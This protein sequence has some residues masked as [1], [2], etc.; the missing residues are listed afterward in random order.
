MWEI[1]CPP[2]ACIL[3]REVDIPINNYKKLCWENSWLGEKIPGKLVSELI[4]AGCQTESQELREGDRH[5]SSWKAGDR[6]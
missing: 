2:E 6:K 5:R 1:F 3:L 4:L